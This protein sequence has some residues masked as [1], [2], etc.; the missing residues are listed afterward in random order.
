MFTQILCPIDGSPGS[1]QALEVAAKLAVE[2]HAKLTICTVVDPARAA[3]MAF[4]DP[5]MS[6]AC[7]NALDEEAKAL[8]KDAAARVKSYSAAEIAALSGQAVSAILDYANS[9]GADLIVM[10]SHGL[11]GIGRALLGSVAEGVLRH[12]ATPV[13][14]IR[15]SRHA[16][17]TQLGARKLETR[18]A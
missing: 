5:G 7:Y 8:L 3:A 6:A 12:S 18:V 14:I 9:S 16:A 1:L 13:M 15:Y 4:G 10:G 2:Q 17:N 11:S